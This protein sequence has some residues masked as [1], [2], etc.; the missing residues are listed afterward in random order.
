[1]IN[2]SKS[3]SLCICTVGENII[4]APK[5]QNHFWCPIKLLLFQYCDSD[6]RLFYTA[7]CKVIALNLLCF[8]LSI[9]FC[10]FS[11][12][13]SIVIAIAII[14]AFGVDSN[15]FY[16]HTFKNEEER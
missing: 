14:V 7:P 13:L 8:N 15:K 4:G 11:C 5:M 3:I 10:F 2:L 1:M 16:L 9:S 12:L 6:I